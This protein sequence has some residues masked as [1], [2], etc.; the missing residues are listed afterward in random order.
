M[1][2]LALCRYQVAFD[3]LFMSGRKPLNG[4]SGTTAATELVS[5]VHS[6]HLTCSPPSTQSS[7]QPSSANNR[8]MLNMPLNE[9]SSGNSRVP[10]SSLSKFGHLV[11]ERE[12]PITSLATSSQDDAAE[13]RNI[14]AAVDPREIPTRSENSIDPQPQFAKSDLRSRLLSRLKEERTHAC[15]F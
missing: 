4:M 6:S 1:Q 13:I 9:E 14:Q 15:N 7:Q 5:S 11:I 3:L 8:P 12:N 2:E 10:P